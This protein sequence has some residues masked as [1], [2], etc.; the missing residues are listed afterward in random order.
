MEYTM[1]W[2]HDHVEVFDANGRFVFS[3]QIRNRKP[4]VIYGRLP[5]RLLAYLFF[6]GAACG[7]IEKNELY[8]QEEI[9]VVD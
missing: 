9:Y 6:F 2:V 8:Q 7:T 5:K 3:G 4:A 1:K